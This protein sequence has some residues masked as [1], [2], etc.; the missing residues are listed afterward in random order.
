MFLR[1]TNLDNNL[2]LINCNS[3]DAIF[4]DVV[5]R[6][7]VT[8]IGLSNGCYLIVKETVSEISLWLQAANK[9]VQ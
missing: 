3:I 6:R 8:K 1:L 9:V 4:L 7:T 5:K 2:Q